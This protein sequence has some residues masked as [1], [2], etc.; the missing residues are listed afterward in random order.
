MREFGYQKPNVLKKRQAA[1]K[2]RIKN[3]PMPKEWSPTR[4][5]LPETD[6]VFEEAMGIVDQAF[7]GKTMWTRADQTGLSVSTLSK[8][9]QLKTKYPRLISVQMQLK[10]IG[11]RL[12]I[13][14]DNRN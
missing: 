1:A 9:R 7:K 5:T 13:A 3:A 11:F 2:E 10:A 14:R 8:H 4:P 12:I 6:A